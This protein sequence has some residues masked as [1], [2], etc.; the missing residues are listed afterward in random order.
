MRPGMTLCTVLTTSFCSEAHSD[1][2]GGKKK[3]ILSPNI[4]L[5]LLAF[6]LILRWGFFVIFGYFYSWPMQKPNLKASPPALH[7]RRFIFFFT[8]LTRFFW[9]RL[10]ALIPPILY[11][12]LQTI[13][14]TG[15][16]CSE[17]HT[18]AVGI[19]GQDQCLQRQRRSS[20]FHQTEPGRVFLTISEGQQNKGFPLLPSTQP[21]HH[22][23]VQ[24][25]RVG[26]R[27]SFTSKLRD[28]LC[29]D[30]GLILPRCYGLLSV[31]DQTNYATIYLRPV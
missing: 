13:V 31:L 21:A 29:A 3:K 25:S 17:K 10:H 5:K 24:P 30:S 16:R 15:L 2:H 8:F 4:F 27:D 18:Q 26:V 9:E 11:G 14:P 7:W 19:C 1:F 23:G 22:C 28:K 12:Q 20:F 6:C